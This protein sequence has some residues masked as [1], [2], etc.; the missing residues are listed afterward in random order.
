MGNPPPLV[1]GRNLGAREKNFAGGTRKVKKNWVRKVIILLN[2][3][4]S[5]P[6]ASKNDK[7]ALR[8]EKDIF[9]PQNALFVWSRGGVFFKNLGA[10]EFLEGGTITPPPKCV[11]GFD[12]SFRAYMP[13]RY[14]YKT[15]SFP[16]F[17]GTGLH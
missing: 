15:A 9:C 17:I 16:H 11:T 13:R 4:K 1:E 14:M 3:L 6:N 2:R 8:G 7:N 10:Q 12:V 5:I